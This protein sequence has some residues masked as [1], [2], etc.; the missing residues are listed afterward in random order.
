MIAEVIIQSN[1][2]NLNKIFDYHIPT[3]LESKVKVGSRVFVPF[4]R[5]KKLEDG[6]VVEVKDIAS[7]QDE[8]V[9]DENRINVAKWM[10]NRYFCNL[11]DCLKLMLPPGTTTK[12]FENRVKEKNINFITLK[13]DKDEIEADIESGKIKTDK[14]IRALRFVMENGDVLMSDLEMFADITRAVV[15]TLCKKGYLEIIEKMVERNPFE[16]KKVEKTEKLTLTDEQQKAYD[17]IANS[18]EDMMFSEFLIH[19]V[20]GSRKDRNLFATN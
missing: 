4:S 8:Q 16:Y 2:R 15:Q 17:E 7:M 19:G 13:M 12:K 20:T 6:F 1:V 5:M 11:A 10:A 3:D 9:L 14:Q 18:M